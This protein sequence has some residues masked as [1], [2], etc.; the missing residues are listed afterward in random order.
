MFGAR[1]GLFR[2]PILGW[3]MRNT[4]TVPIYRV[5]DAKNGATD[6]RRYANAQSIDALAADVAGGSF[7]AL[8]PEG[9]SHDAPLRGLGA[10]PIR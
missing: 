1:H 7:S 3:L 5:V 4:G 2:V 8:F 6:V 10:A 9:V